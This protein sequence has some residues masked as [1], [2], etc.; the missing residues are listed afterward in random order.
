VLEGKHVQREVFQE[1][2]F[3]RATVNPFPDEQEQLEHR[4]WAELDNVLSL[5][6]QVQ[7]RAWLPLSDGLFPF[8]RA[9]VVIHLG[10]QGSWFRWQVVHIDGENRFRYE[11]EWHGPSLPAKYQRL[12]DGPLAETADSGREG[13]P[14]R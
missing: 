14:R 8:G 7:A 12:W 5:P 3:V 11:G 13:S 4:V 9:K 6:Q 10:R 2:Q 1:G